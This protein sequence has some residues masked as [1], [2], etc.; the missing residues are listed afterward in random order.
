[1]GI[2][3]R[4]FV[5]ICTDIHICRR[6]HDHRRCKVC[7]CADAASARH[8]TYAVLS[9]KLPCRDGI[10]VEERELA[11]CHIS[12]LSKTK[13]TENHFLHPRIYFP[14]SVD[15]FSH[16]DIAA[17]E[18]GYRIIESISVCHSNFKSLIVSTI[19][20]YV[21]CWAGTRGRRNS[22]SINPIA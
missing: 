12:Q 6:H 14:L 5:H 7:S 22:F 17:L 2:D 11:F 15:F 19:R 1:M 21:L 8:D 4:T 20:S 16:T 9:S 13:T 3:H 18:R 10:L